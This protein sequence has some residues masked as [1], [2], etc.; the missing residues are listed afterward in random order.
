MSSQPTG[1]PP[2]PSW[3]ARIQAALADGAAW[4]Q[5][6]LLVVLLGSAALI[7]YLLGTQQTEFIYA[8]F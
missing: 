1:T 7:L 6:P 4:W 3:D 2:K 8:L 5:A